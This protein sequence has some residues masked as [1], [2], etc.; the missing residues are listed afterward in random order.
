[1]AVWRHEPSSGGL[2]A[3]AASGRQ[4]R[5]DLYADRSGGDLP[6]P[7]TH[8][9]RAGI[10]PGSEISVRGRLG[11]GSERGTSD[12]QSRSV[13]FGGSFY[14]RARVRGHMKDN[15]GRPFVF[16]ELDIILEM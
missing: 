11:P 1:M 6:R 5:R 13:G 8:T 2:A 12:S 4:K 7:A 10:R 9:R 3:I 16:D 15:L 14:D